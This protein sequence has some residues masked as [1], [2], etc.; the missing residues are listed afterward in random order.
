MNARAQVLNRHRPQL[1]SLVRLASFT[2]NNLRVVN[3]LP[4]D[5]QLPSV[6][7]QRQFGTLVEEFAFR[8]R[9]DSNGTR[10]LEHV[11]TVQTRR[12]ARRRPPW[13][14]RAASTIINGIRPKENASD[15]S[16]TRNTIPRPLSARISANSASSTIQT[17]IHAQAQSRNAQSAWSSTRSSSD[18]NALKV[19][20]TGIAR[21]PWLVSNFANRTSTTITWIKNVTLCDC[22]HIWLY[23]VI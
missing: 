22:F 6:R 1:Q 9:P 14:T 21:R 20:A 10:L 16:L 12:N 15:A 4:Q 7:L 13:P 5:P 11:W 19:L 17:T 23:S 8:A 3:R 18:A 2:I